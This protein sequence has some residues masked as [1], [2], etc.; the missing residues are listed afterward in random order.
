MKNPSELQPTP[1]QIA[2]RKSGRPFEG[3][4]RE[5]KKDATRRALVRAANVRFHSFGFDATTIDEI[6]AD[7]E[8]SRRT[9]FRYFANKE[10]LAFPHR[11]ERL[12]R[13]LELLEG[14]PLNECPFISLRQIAQVFAREYSLNR[15]QQLAQQQLINRTPALV[16]RENEIDRDWENAMAE[17]FIQRYASG[18]RNSG[19]QIE[20]HAR[21]LAGAAIGVIRATLRHWFAM[22][23]NADLASLGAQALDALQSGFKMVAGRN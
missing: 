14:A 13:F 8:V 5:R 17:V 23:G 1:T 18:G 11:A 22:Q 16:A 10:A 15:E 19:T 4:L 12:E 9:F 7:A 20:L 21:M 6:C 3:K 2:P